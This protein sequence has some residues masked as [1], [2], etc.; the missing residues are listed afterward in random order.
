MIS[1]VSILGTGVSVLAL[2]LV[3]SIM[4]GFNK[5]IVKKLLAAEPHLVYYP[6]DHQFEQAYTKLSE[7][8][9]VQPFYYRQQDVIIKTVDGAFSGG[10]AK[11]IE[12]EFLDSF[13]S[14]KRDSQFLYQSEDD[15]A[16]E[17]FRLKPHEVIMGIGLARS[18]GVFEGDE[19]LVFPAEALLLPDGEL[20][21]Y[22]KVTVKEVFSTEIEDVDT[23]YFYYNLG[24]SLTTLSDGASVE[25]GIEIYLKDP[26]RWRSVKSVIEKWGGRVESW[27]DRN[28]LLFFAL[29]LEKIAVS[30]FLTLGVV[31]TSFSIFSVLLLLIT[32]KRRDIGVLMAFGLSPK[33]TQEVFM[34]V[35][36]IL[37]GIGLGGGLVVGV[38]IALILHF[39]PVEVLPDI[40][41]DRS[42]PAD[43]DPVFLLYVLVGVALLALLSSW[44]PV[45]RLKGVK[46]REL[47]E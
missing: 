22:D 9:G 23:Q 35:G 25:R 33:K 42:I 16:R 15:R 5:S 47:F 17:S 38:S 32:Q 4:G 21:P 34:G 24:E 13:L 41:Y 26:S 20:P 40:Y 43:V 11:G 10:I 37:T 45:R 2:V 18:L 3:L 39:F 6:K 31:I 19:V 8:K 44:L 27:K 28:A 29:K 36:L 14:H 30:I 7:M 12:P 46:V 1:K